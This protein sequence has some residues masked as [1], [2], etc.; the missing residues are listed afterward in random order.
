[1]LVDAAAA[2]RLIKIAPEPKPGQLQSRTAP[3]GPPTDEDGCL[4]PP[5][6]GWSIAQ[7]AGS[8]CPS[9]SLLC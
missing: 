9:G 4:Y 7:A 2:A 6:E 3:C 8:G 5:N 1:M